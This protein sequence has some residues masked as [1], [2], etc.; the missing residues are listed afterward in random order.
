M[1]KKDE[2]NNEL[3]EISPFLSDLN[4]D[5]KEGFSIPKNYFDNFENRLM[6]RIREE[7]AL[8]GSKIADSVDNTIFSWIQNAVKLLFTPKYA[9]SF[10]I[11][12]VAVVF[13][14]QFFSIST[15]DTTQEPSLIAQL[16]I[17]ETHLFIVNNIHDFSIDDIIEIVETEVIE[18]LHIDLPSLHYENKNEKQVINK[19][20]D[21]QSSFD[22]A[23]ES[24][25][26]KNLFDELSDE[27]F[28]EAYDEG[29]F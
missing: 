7:E 5:R 2:I 28:D 3:N 14:I 20:K 23:L 13:G 22:K 8:S 11:A 26:A 19:E 24:A 25:E 15:S 16:S 10:S 17:E 1:N 6:S 18:D 4:K 29:Y 12:V 27:D 9:V 21:K